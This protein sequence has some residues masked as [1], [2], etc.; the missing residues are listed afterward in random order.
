MDT[1]ALLPLVHNAALLLALVFLHDVLTR[2]WLRQHLLLRDVPLGLVLGG[3]GMAVMLTPWVLEPGVIFDTRTVLLAISGLFFGPLPTLIAMAMTAALRLQMGGPAAVTGVATIIA[4]GGL[5]IGWRLW[6]RGRGRELVELS[7][8]QLY[9]FGF[10][11]H[12]LVLALM[13]L[14]PRPTAHQVL[15]QIS[16]PFLLIH[17]LATSLLGVLM[18]NRLRQ[19]RM[20]DRLRQSESCYRELSQNLERRVE[21]R[22]RQLEEVNREL[23]S[24]AYSVSHDLR[25]PL[26][27]MSN[28]STILLRQHAA[29]LGE[30]GR[31][32]CGNIGAAC[33]NMVELIEGLLQFSRLGRAELR[34]R[35][36][37]MAAMVDSV[38]REVRA[39]FA[40]EPPPTAGTPPRPPAVAPEF[41]RGELPAAEGDPGLLGQVWYNLLH[42]AVKFSAGATPPRIRVSGRREEG[43]AVY[44]VEDNG[45]GFPERESRRLFQ[46]FQR[47][48]GDDEFPGSGA[49]LA[50]VRRIVE[51]HGGR[52]WARSVP[53]R[54]AGFYF[55]LPA[56]APA[57]S[58][59]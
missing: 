59:A 20:V 41:F 51:R 57:Q 12:L 29:A 58:G 48:H 3:I 6:W 44:L 1:V 55:S 7:G 23:D 33:R 31:R 40:A 2:Q 37:D 4:A 52:V 16:L 9:L 19:E 39:A 25:A 17:P 36:V 45:V 14:L 28:Y 15:S 50:I 54:G 35:P 11:L 22:T 42:N 46:V 26:R 8:L 10:L 18:I 27:A 56:A 32:I 43:M 49:W 5:G 21:E 13:L 53:D 47:L 34:K 24:F 30:D 38:Y